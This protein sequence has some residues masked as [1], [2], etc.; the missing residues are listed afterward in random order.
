MSEV[1]VPILLTGNVRCALFIFKVSQSIG[2]KACR[3]LTVPELS[4]QTQLK[5]GTVGVAALNEAPK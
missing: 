2:G 5:P 4:H 3:F 1:G